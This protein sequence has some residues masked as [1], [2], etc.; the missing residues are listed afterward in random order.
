MNLRS[1]EVRNF[2][3]LR[4]RTITFAA[5][6]VLIGK[7]DSGKSNILNA[8]R[9]LCEG[10]PTSIT[11]EDFYDLEVPIEITG[12]FGDVR[13]HLQLCDQNNRPR[14]EERINER[15]EIVL[16]RVSN[17]RKLGKLEMQNADGTFGLPV[18]IE[19]AL[20]PV[21][22][23]IVY[24]GAL[25]DV[26]KESK[27]A[28]KN[29]LG[30]LLAYGMDLI[31]EEV[32]PE[33]NI[34][35]ATADRLINAER[36][37]DR[38]V[39]PIREIENEIDRYLEETFPNVGVRLKVDLPG[40]REIFARTEVFVVEG[41]NIDRPT[42]RGHGLQRSLLLSLLRALADRARAGQRLRR[43]FILLFEEPE[44]F[45]HPDAQSKMRE[46]LRGISQAAQVIFTTHSPLL[47]SPDSFQSILRVEKVLAQPNLKPDTRVYGR[48]AI[49]NGRIEEREISAI[50]SL[51][52]SSRFLFSRSVL[53][54][55]GI[56]DEHIFSA[57]TRS[58]GNFDLEENGFAIVEMGG[59]NICRSFIDVLRRLELNVWAL[60]D[61][62]FAWNGAGQLLVGNDGHRLFLE[63]LRAAVPDL[64]PGATDRERR[65][66]KEARFNE[67]RNGLRDETLALATLLEGHRILLLVAGEIEDYAGL[68]Q[69]AK[70]KYIK[71]AQE[72]R[73][74][75]RI[76]Q[77]PDDVQR[78]IAALRR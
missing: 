76:V 56:A 32:E 14:L 55:E 68:G 71:A 50:F 31:S 75:A 23:E 61:L 42:M 7:N 78:K 28:Q 73:S 74:G 4:D 35:L 44:A 64:P 13:R 11:E 40:V 66:C 22:P 53:L 39:A 70:N 26:A 29:T 15:D 45:L 63:H 18:G 62:D 36:G 5:F 49:D 47:I 12:T 65:E 25:D 69:N 60:V 57:A 19:A 38:R 21:V 10:T 37:E 67:C 2:R 30:K 9:L 20:K 43:P 6:N 24:I 3:S 33:L 1:L 72:I 48:M 77:H 51:Q 46:A 34:A 16:R 52:R 54:V 58:V 41:A 8:I 17:E 59:K 27:G